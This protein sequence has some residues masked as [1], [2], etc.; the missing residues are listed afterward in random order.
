MSKRRVL[1]L[2]PIVLAL[3]LATLAC[4][5]TSPGLVG[6]P[7]LPPLDERGE[8]LL[9]RRALQDGRALRQEGRLDAAERT[10]HRGLA[11]RPDDARLERELA[12]VL[13]AAGRP[14]EAAAARARADR[15]DPPPPPL[16][17]APLAVGPGHTVVVIV[18]STDALR[19]DD[20]PR[21]PDPAVEAAVA[22]RVAVRAPEASLLRADPESVGEAAHVLEERD[23]A[24]AVSLRVDRADCRSSLKDGEIAVAELRVAAAV[25]GHAARPAT[26]AKVVL[27]DPPADDCAGAAVERAFEQALAGEAWRDAAARSPAPDAGWQVHAREL[28]PGI[29]RRIAR[30][31]RHGESL[32]RAGELGL[33]LRAFE[34]AARLDPG[35]AE[36]RAYLDD[37]RQSLAMARSIA[38][39]TADG[40]PEAVDPRLS[41]AQRT[42]AEQALAREEERR[43]ELLGALAILDEDVR[44][45]SRAT[46]DTLRPSEIARPDDFGPALARR[47]SGGPV[48]ARAAF[49]PDGTRLARYYFSPGETSPVVL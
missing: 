8:T 39:R 41:A 33:A 31:L 15:L 23:A 14:D 28:F 26:R 1:G 5:S 45:P 12:R 3:L 18:P 6:E 7:D 10:L 24:R 22:R 11:L 20:P 49:A 25:R 46:L 2:A 35:D 4:E 37:P 19:P 13:E 9:A 34:D 29:G 40:E 16:P 36:T 30:Q 44:A 21:W 38:A 17:D 27:E 47:R 32:L 48:E 43:H 42:A